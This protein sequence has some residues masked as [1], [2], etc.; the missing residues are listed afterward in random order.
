MP[1]V[2]NQYYAYA[3]TNYG[4]GFSNLIKLA[5]GTPASSGGAI[6]YPGS[7]NVDLLGDGVHNAFT[8]GGTTYTYE[9]T[10]TVGSV[11]GFVAETNGQLYFFATTASLSNSAY[12]TW[13]SN[14]QLPQP[15]A[16]GSPGTGEWS[17]LTAAEACFVEGTQILTPN[18]EAAVETLK[19]GDAVMT[20]DGVARRIRWV[21]RT[22]KSRLFGDRAAVTPIRIKAG[23]LGEGRPARDLLVSPGHGVFVDGLL[24]N[25]SALVN[26]GSIAPAEDAPVLFTYYHVELDRHD[27]ILAEGLEVES[28]I[29]ATSDLNMDNLAERAT[30]ES[31]APAAEMAYPR[32]KSARQLPSR[33]QVLLGGETAGSIAA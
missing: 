27:L 8:F 9:G 10:A 16:I 13:L 20:A 19:A 33:I 22:A 26:G 5:A 18:G 6:T 1:S 31:P 12:D 2:A 11:N 24:V 7:P 17:L 4:S 29:E 25:A 14:A 32:V 15:P 28:F 23:A 21:G 30:L 3:L